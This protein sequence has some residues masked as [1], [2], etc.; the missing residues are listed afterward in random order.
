MTYEKERHKFYYKVL[1]YERKRHK[2]YYR[3]TLPLFIL[4]YQ[5]YFCLFLPYNV[6]F[7]LMSNMKGSRFMLSY[8]FSME[9]KCVRIAM[10]D[11]KHKNIEHILILSGDH[12]CR[13]DYMKFLE[14]QVQM[15]L[16]HHL[17]VFSNWYWLMRTAIVETYWDKCWYHSFMC[18]NGWKVNIYMQNLCDLVLFFHN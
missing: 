11:A 2:F 9:W 18:T 6:T 16:H 10:Q 3:R 14:V 1:C 12:L 17:I 8:Q 13:M 4:I 5:F 15:R 7:I